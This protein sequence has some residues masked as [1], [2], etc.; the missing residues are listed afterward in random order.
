MSSLFEHTCPC[1][2][3]R[4]S[5]YATEL[6]CPACGRGMLVRG[7]APP[8]ERH[9][10]RSA[11]VALWLLDWVVAPILIVLGV[12]TVGSVCALLWLGRAVGLIREDA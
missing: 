11:R 4:V 2:T 9:E 5:L 3:R 1:G 6:R 7:V 12:I 10:P 8:S